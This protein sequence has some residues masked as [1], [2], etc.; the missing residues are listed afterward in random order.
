ML[1]SVMYDVGCF[2]DCWL[3]GFRIGVKAM[4]EKVSADARLHRV[5][6][7]CNLEFRHLHSATS[8]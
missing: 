1:G 6:E 3:K 5:D 8:I 7:R 4:V 2:L